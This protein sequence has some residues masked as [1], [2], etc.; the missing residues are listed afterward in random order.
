MNAPV[1]YEVHNNVARIT[2]NRP[3]GGNVVNSD[4][5]ELLWQ[6]IRR[7]ES[8]EAC[9]AIV[10]EGRDGVFSRGM[11]FRSTIA[12]YEEGL[13]RDFAEPYRRTVLAIRNSAKPVVAAV[14]GDVIAGGMGLAL[15][16]DM[17][18]ATRRSRFGLTE[19][20]F[21]LIPA[22]VFPLL[23]ERVSLKRARYMVLSSRTFTAD[24]SMGMGLVDEVVEDAA[25]ERALTGYLK[26]LLASSP[27]AL[28]AVKSYTDA[29]HGQPLDQ[30]MTAARD[31]LYELLCRAGTVDAIRDF[32]EGE[33][34]PWSVKYRRLQRGE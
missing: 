2:L 22:Y 23:L 18:V 29:V 3:E 26:R 12:Q 30:A 1:L 33:G 25:L 10:L 28:A 31:Q 24:E 11:D 13:E 19:V 15:A 5:L 8:D 20:L 7:A 17:V 6:G 32:F 9:R 16:C 14:D 21:G 4:N 27:A 34:M